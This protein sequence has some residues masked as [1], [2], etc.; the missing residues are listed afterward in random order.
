MTLAS[1]PPSP[2][3]PI[4][5]G[6]LALVVGPSGAGKDTLINAARV[7]L[8]GDPHFVFP[9]RI[10]TRASHDA[11]EEHDM[12][13]PEAFDTA[14]RSGAFLLSWR[15]HGLGYAVPGSARD[16]LRAGHVV[17]ANV[18]RGAI[19]EAEQQ[20]RRVTVLHVTAPIDELAR[21]IALRG[22]EAEAD[23]AARLARQAPLTAQR[24][25]VI[26]IVNDT[27][28]EDAAR[29]FVTALRAVAALETGSAR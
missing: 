13:T 25:S 9:R 26:E 5:T 4:E 28:P 18:S 7:A 24:A 21:R 14:A 3:K 16:P 2:K 15:A 22:R 8:A 20:V 29:R 19:V 23:I 17:V 10:V 6:T 12:M 27:A 1:L 11:S